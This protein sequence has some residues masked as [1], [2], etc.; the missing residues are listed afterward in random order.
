[1]AD[2]G[3]RLD[4]E[5]QKRI[6]RLAAYVPSRSEIARRADVSRPT[7]YKYLQKKNSRQV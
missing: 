3:K 2:Q 6:E 1:M 7:V 4:A 5:T